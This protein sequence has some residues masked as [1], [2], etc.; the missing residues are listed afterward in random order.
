VFSYIW[1]E[2]TERVL[3]YGLMRGWVDGWMSER[4]DGGRKLQVFSV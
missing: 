3:S 4:V 2:E 1:E